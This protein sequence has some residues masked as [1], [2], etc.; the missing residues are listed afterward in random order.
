MVNRRFFRSIPLLLVV[1]AAPVIGCT[2][3]TVIHSHG[4]A[5]ELTDAIT[6]SGTGEATAEPDIARLRIGV[7]ARHED[8]QKAIEASNRKTEAMLQALKALGIAEQDLQTTEF[9]IHSERYD[10]PPPP[11]PPRP[12]PEGA[13]DAPDQPRREPLLRYRVSNMLLVTVRNLDNL[14]KVLQAATQAGA[15]QAWGIE[16]DVDNREPVL[17]KARE[18]A[19]A[20]ARDRAEQLAR[21]A[22]VKLGKVLSVAEASV[23]IVRPA[24]KMMEAARSSVPVERGNLEF[25]EQVRMVFEIAR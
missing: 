16:F 2:P 7:E 11:P 19:V 20:N 8:P 5:P 13:K 4:S 15:N 24:M 23:P 12:L 6:V 21:T 10:T 3:T 1:A 25:S 17:A 9:N 18:R 22:G 14:G